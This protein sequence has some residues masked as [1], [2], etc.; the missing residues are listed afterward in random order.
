[1]TEEKDGPK[2]LWHDSCSRLDRKVP[3]HD[4][5]Q[6]GMTIR[7]SFIAKNFTMTEERDKLKPL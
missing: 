1:M 2:S 3:Q 7:L 6:L 5:S 4:L